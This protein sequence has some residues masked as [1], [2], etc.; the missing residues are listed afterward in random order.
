MLADRLDRQWRSRRAST[1]IDV[2]MR[3][4]DEGLVLGAGA[5]LAR[6]GASARDILIDV[7]EPRL[8]ALLS[9]AHLRPPTASALAHLRKAAERWRKGENDLAAIHLALSGVS[10]LDQPQADA[11]RLFLADALLQV[12]L[13]PD[14]LLKALNLDAAPID[15]LTK[16]SPDQPRAPAGSGRTSGEWTATGAESAPTA[17]APLI[18]RRR[19]RRR[20][21]SARNRSDQPP[22][23]AWARRRSP[24]QS[25]SALGQ[26]GRGG[27]I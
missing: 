13:E 14:T 23:P 1:P 21:R 26:D 8:S 15:R 16:F 9:A 12:G 22:R 19:E 3:F 5:V 6:S 24:R 2:V 20:T 10:R 18:S 7:R 11:Q 25:P 27:G 4:S 17:A